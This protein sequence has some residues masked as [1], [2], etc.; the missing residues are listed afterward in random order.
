MYYG[1]KDTPMNTHGFSDVQIQKIKR[2]YDYAIGK[3]FNYDLE[4]HRND[5][6]K[7]VDEHDR[8]RGT[9]FIEVFPE[10][11]DFYVKYKK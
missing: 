6:I 11:K 3:S 5:F 8:R 2:T 9:N 10:L 4:K 7:F 1:M